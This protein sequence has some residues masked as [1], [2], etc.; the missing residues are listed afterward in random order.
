MPGSSVGV[1]R[2][3]SEGRGWCASCGGAKDGNAVVATVVIDSTP[4]LSGCSTTTT[5]SSNHV[6]V[7]PRFQAEGGYRCQEMGMCVAVYCGC[8]LIF[9]LSISL[10][11]LEVK[12]KV[13]C[14]G[15]HSA[16]KKVVATAIPGLLPRRLLLEVFYWPL[17]IV[18]RCF[19]ERTQQVLSC[20][21]TVANPH[22]VDCPFAKPQLS[23]DS[24]STKP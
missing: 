24:S 5:S 23:V 2:R 20:Y 16:W 10:P 9:E 4:H 19:V 17:P 15:S 22:L 7:S 8:P 1:P 12:K 14:Q 6:F 11:C 13:G 3:A 18:S 21:Q